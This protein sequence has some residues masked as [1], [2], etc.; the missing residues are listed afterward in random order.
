[1]MKTRTL[2]LVAMLLGITSTGCN[3]FLTGD[4]LSNNPNE[5]TGATADQLFIGVQVQVM[6][7]WETYPM[8]LLPLWAQQ[9][10]GVNRQWQSYSNFGSGLDNVT[11]DPMWNAFYGGGGL[12]DVRRVKE[13]AS[14]SG[15]QKLVGQVRV[16][17]ALYAG[18]AADVWGSVPYDAAGTPAPTF[19]T[20]ARVYEHV[21][22]TLDSAIT[23]LAGAGSG[24]A[25]DFYLGGD[26]SAWT[27]VAHTL[28]ARFYMHTAE[29]SDLTYDNAILQNVLNETANGISSPE[30]SLET[31]HT[32]NNL[33][34]NLFYEFLIGSRK[35]D[36]E[37]SA[38]HI[39]LA[40]QLNDD[41]MLAQTYNRNSGGNY[42]G[43]AAGQTGG[44]AVSTFAM[45]P[46]TSTGV[47]TY[48]ENAL[49]SAE[50]HY[51]LGAS[52]LAQSDLDAERAAY[53]ETGATPISGATN[54]LL[55]T[56]LREKFVRLFLNPEVYFD[57]LRT[58]VPNVPLP[59]NHSSAFFYVP[60]RVPYGYTESTT[61][62]NIPADPLTNGNWPKHPTDPSGATCA[63]Q[64]QRPGA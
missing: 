31:K 3:G 33:E 6:A 1:M 55:I 7:Q 39:S 14:A 64:A 20:Q 35:G 44:N 15:N 37:P 61:N 17:E 30:G 54:G 40:N 62:P 49:L 60:A 45:G 57:Y 8:N 29:K 48:A 32:E 41:V 5:P 59:A 56:I 27:A 9:I 46:A 52:A 36:V 22:A 63:G 11:W 43:S 21:Q 16:L 18:T 51:R 12:A 26:F 25:V 47:V 34:H 42:V 10:A 2:A 13:E 50:A 23:D 4:K 28:K 53:G 58:C 38:L 19:D 24:A